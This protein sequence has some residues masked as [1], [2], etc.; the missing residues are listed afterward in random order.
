[1][2]GDGA[3]IWA[4]AD[5]AGLEERSAAEGIAALARAEILRREPPLGFVHPLV[6]D[7]VYLDLP[8]GEQSLSTSAPPG[9]CTTRMRSPSRSRPIC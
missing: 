6:R 3:E 8:P 1:M 2:L 4:V 5:L 9:S 7:A